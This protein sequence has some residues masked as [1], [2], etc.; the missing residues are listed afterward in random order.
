[1]ATVAGFQFD[2]SFDPSLI[3]ADSVTSGGFLPGFNPGMIDNNAGSITDTFYYHTDSGGNPNPGSLARITFTAKVNEG[4]STLHLDACKLGD[5]NDQQLP[6]DL[7]DG[8]VILQAS[9]P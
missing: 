6:V 1:M 2:L 7:T 5:P 8:Y 9:A 4:T 3:S